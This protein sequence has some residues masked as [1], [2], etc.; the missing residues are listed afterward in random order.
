[1]SKRNT[2]LVNLLIVWT[3]ALVTCACAHG[4]RADYNSG[5]WTQRNTTAPHN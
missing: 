5:S 2:L 3:I 4:Q 1:M